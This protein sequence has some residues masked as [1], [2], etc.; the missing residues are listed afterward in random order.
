MLRIVVAL[1][2]INVYI[3]IGVCHIKMTIRIVNKYILGHNNYVIID[4]IFFVVNIT[5]LNMHLPL[6]N[7]TI[8]RYI[9]Y[10]WEP[11]ED[12]VQPCDC[13]TVITKYTVMKLYE[14]VYP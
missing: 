2:R 11:Q 4:A 13:P 6:V 10:K 1:L 14:Y 9:I 7:I 5:V 12:G 3:F 8:L